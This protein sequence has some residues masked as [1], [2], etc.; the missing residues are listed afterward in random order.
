MSAKDDIL[1]AVNGEPIEAIVVGAWGGWGA[2]PL[3]RDEDGNIEYEYDEPAEPF[4]ADKR[5]VVLT[6][7]EALPYLENWSCYGGYGS[8]E[9]YAITLWTPSSVLF[10]SQYNG[11]TCLN[12][13]PR[14]PI[15]HSPHMPGGG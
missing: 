14:N 15:D 11:S 2:V 10:L 13:V 4:P 9:T 3:M 5:G 8:P 6:W 1:S 12:D 7:D